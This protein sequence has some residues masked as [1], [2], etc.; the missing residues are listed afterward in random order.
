MSGSPWKRQ[1]HEGVL[2]KFGGREPDTEVIPKLRALLAGGSTLA[3][4]ATQLGLKVHR[5]Y[6]LAVRYNMPRRRNANRTIEKGEMVYIRNGKAYPHE[7]T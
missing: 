1:M 3:N 4:A 7:P 6:E 2:K 5:T